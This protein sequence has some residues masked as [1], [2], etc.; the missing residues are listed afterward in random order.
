MFVSML[1]VY[2]LP[3]DPNP[4]VLPILYF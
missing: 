4:C 3:L 1:E 2:T